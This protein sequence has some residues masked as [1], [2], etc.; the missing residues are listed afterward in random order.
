[1]NIAFLALLGVALGV[2]LAG[3]PGPITAVMVRQA[4]IRP[5]L[6][7]LVGLGAMSADFILMVVV[8]AAG[9][10]AGLSR[11]EEIVFILG[12][13][14]FFYLAYRTMKSKESVDE[15]KAKGYVTGLTLGLV[16]PFQIGWWLTA[17]LGIYYAF[18]VIP[19]IFLFAG[20]IA[21]ISLLSELVHLGSIKYGQRMQKGIRAFSFCTLAFFG[22]LFMY[23][24]ILPILG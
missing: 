4:V 15:G 19:F 13:F 16:N 12:A 17:G 2:S 14:F 8:F 7:V 18:G 9:Y 20:I 21:W 22:I 24:A 11:Y 1:M 6:G 10:A 3:P 23:S 5:I